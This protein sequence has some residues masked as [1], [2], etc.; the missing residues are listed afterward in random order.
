MEQQR[1]GDR[2]Q[3]D[4]DIDDLPRNA[5][6]PSLTL[7]PLLENAIYHGVE[8]LREPGA[9]E[10]S[11]RRKGNRVYIRVRNQRPIDKYKSSPGNRIALD[12]IR[13]RLLLAFGPGSGL[14]L[15]VDE[16][17]YEVTLAFP[18]KDTA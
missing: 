5:R 2:L 17:H 1:L 6:I 10:V 13:E 8:P 9:V 11:G 12:N 4:W 3:I 16:T 15:A 18:F 7:Q 14:S